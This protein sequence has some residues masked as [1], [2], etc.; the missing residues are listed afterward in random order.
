MLFRQNAQTASACFGLPLGKLVS[1]AAADIIVVD[2]DPPTPLTSSN[3]LGHV[4]FGVS[5]RSV[6]TTIIDGRIVMRDRKI[7]HIDE[8]AL[9]AKARAAARSM[10]A[11]F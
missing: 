1:G 3:I 11:R 2:Y 10:W 7:P 6:Q 4:L 8:D 5:G 9:M